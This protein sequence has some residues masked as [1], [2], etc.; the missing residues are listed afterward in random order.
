MHLFETRSQVLDVIVVRFKVRP[1][2]LD[3]A[4]AVIEDFVR[5]VKQKELGLLEYQSLRDKRDPSVFLHYMQF[6]DQGSH[7]SHRQA[8]YVKDFVRKLYPLCEDDPEAQ[9]FDV[10]ASASRP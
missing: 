2:V 1:E 9:S 10:F 7:R 5:A 8:Q 3:H 4:E 6:Q